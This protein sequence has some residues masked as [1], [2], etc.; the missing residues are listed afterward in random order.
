MP[1]RRKIDSAGHIINRVDKLAA[2]VRS[3]VREITQ[4]G[5]GAVAPFPMKEY[6][7]FR[8]RVKIITKDKGLCFAP[9]FGSQKYLIEQIAVGL[10]RGITDFK[11]LKA[12]QL[13]ITTEMRI[14]ALFWMFR[15]NGLCATYAVHEDRAKESFRQSLNTYFSHLP[16]THKW[17]TKVENREML[18]LTNDSV[19]VYLTAGTKERKTGMGRS[20]SFNFLMADEVAFWGTP[21]DIKQFEATL[22]L[23]YPHRL[24]LWASTA[25]GFN[26]FADMCESAKDSL[27]S[28]FIFDG[29]YRSEAYRFERGT[30]LFEAYMPGGDEAPLTRLEERRSREVFKLYGITIDREQ[31]A[32][33]RWYLSDKCGGDQNMMDQEYPWVPEDAFIATGSKYFS[34]SALTIANRRARTVPLLPF[35]YNI[36]DE[37][38]ETEVVPSPLKGCDLKIWEEPQHNGIYTIGCDPAFGSS[39]LADRTVISVW[40]CFADRVTQVAEYAS[41]QISTYNCAWVLAHLAGYYVDTLVVL[42]ISGPGQD[43]KKELERLRFLMATDPRYFRNMSPI[44]ENMKEFIYRR[45]DTMGTGGAWHLKINHDLKWLV[46]SELKAGLETHTA[47]INSAGLLDEMK[48][49]QIRDGS[50]N[51]APHAKDDRVTACAYAIHA[52]KTN[53][54][55]RMIA[56]GR[57][58]ER[59]MNPQTARSNVPMEIAVMNYLKTLTISVPTQ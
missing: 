39:D 55:P 47:I 50:L 52:W 23:H 20:G 19:L 11:I 53:V 6:M 30:G 41:N 18:L 24:T 29:W 46:Y 38:A 3:E 34:S 49:I 58:L 14:L 2:E 4:P 37:W 31:I 40:R 57:T 43:V 28:M 8:S 32:W 15:H 12:R 7:D 22:S 54:Q 42:E 5:T 21:E 51:A 1:P 56:E 48:S 35:R 16:K 25:N 17:P 10:S 36:G 44:L 45:V 33:Y 59:E 26:H 9:Q 13:G 27:T